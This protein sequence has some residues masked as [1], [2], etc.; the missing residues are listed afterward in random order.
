MS[1]RS[2]TERARASRE[3]EMPDERRP[4]RLLALQSGGGN[5]AVARMIRKRAAATPRLQRFEEAEHKAIGDTAVGDV[6]FRISPL[7]SLTY[8]D[9]VDLGDYFRSVEEIQGLIK[10]GGEGEGTIGEVYYAVFVMVRGEDEK[11][12]MGEFYD[13]SAKKAVM[14]RFYALAGKNIGHFPNPE[15]GDPARSVQDKD[16]KH[17]AEGAPIGAIATY[18]DGHVHAIRRAQ[19]LGRAGK[20]IGEALVFEAFAGHFLT[21]VFSSGHLRTPRKSIGEYWNQKVPGFSETFQRWMADQVA[22][23]LD[24]AG[25]QPEQALPHGFKRKLALEKIKQALESM[26]AVTF[27]DLVSGAVHDFDSKRGVLADI[28]GKRVRLVGDGQLL[29]RNAKGE[30]VPP[31]RAKSTMEAAVHAV[32]AGVAEVE[33]AYAYGQSGV[34]DPGAVIGALSAGPGRLFAAEKLLPTPVP[35]DQ[36]G[37]EDRSVTWQFESTDKLFEDP[38]MRHALVV[39]ANNKASTLEGIVNDPQISE[40]GRLALKTRVVDRLASTDPN[41]VV[42]LLKEILA[43]KG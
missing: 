28:D 11:K 40:H 35:D 5:A 3:A 33:K 17:D 34:S 18:R 31:A 41:F 30:W 26:P 10:H 21:D 43:Y 32:Q 12:H 27:G 19:E 13:E 15:A 25:N 8:G 37:E 7:V 1:V 38:A 23:F 42:A 24:H 22:I 36:L 39:F 9:F 2:H 29:E 6:A 14:K 4:D 20:P 16:R